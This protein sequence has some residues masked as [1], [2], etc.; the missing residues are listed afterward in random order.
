VDF[1]VFH[2]FKLTLDDSSLLTRAYA[3]SRRLVSHLSDEDAEA[4]RYLAEDAL[5]WLNVQHDGA[6]GL[7]WTIE[8]NSLYLTDDEMF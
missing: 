1:A 4:L 2:G 3:D 7:A 6:N 5:D 8:D